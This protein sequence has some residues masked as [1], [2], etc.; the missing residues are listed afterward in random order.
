MIRT[1]IT[2]TNTLT[3][4]QQKMDV[5]SNNL[6]NSNTHGY[7]AQVTTFEEL[8]Y[9]Q[10]NNDVLDKTARETPVGIRYGVGAG[11]AQL[12]LVT[13]QGNLQTT[14]R[15][16]DF[17]FTTENQYFNV[18][19]DDADGEYNTVYTRQGDFYLSPTGDN[20]VRLVN[21][22]GYPVANAQGEPIVLPEGAE[23]FRMLDGGILSVQYPAQADGTIPT[24]E[25]QIGVTQVYKPQLLE[26]ISATYFDVPTNF[27][28]L[29]YNEEDVL[30]QLEGQARGAIALQNNALEASNVDMSKEMTDLIAT[31]RA[32]QFN[33]RAVTIAD[34][35][36]GLI[37]SARS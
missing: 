12:Q 27:D 21:T 19:M 29:G 28:E 24:I 16:L 37:N 35:M 9:Q 17:A 7:K 10:F 30:M 11:I 36:L 26:H 14:N 4:L 3:N 22:D 15:P 23:N 20:E 31:Q 13:K 6:A 1:M 32:Y 33:S 8:L 2:A 5:T 25:V 18:L 34:Q